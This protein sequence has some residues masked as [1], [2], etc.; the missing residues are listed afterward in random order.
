MKFMENTLLD[1]DQEIQENH[2]VIFTA[3]ST[4][5]KQGHLVMGAGNALA[6]KKA[7]PYLAAEFGK[8]IEDQSRF[9]L[10]E[11]V[12]GFGTV[13]AFQTKVHWKKSTP[14]DLLEESIKAL[15]CTANLQPE[16]TFHLPCPAVNYGGMSISKVKPMLETLPDNVVVYYDK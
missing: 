9:H 12:V 3:N 10:C 15:S 4:I 16:V 14:L 5:N 1:Y 2:C 7:Y 13:M 8:L 6:C 11:V